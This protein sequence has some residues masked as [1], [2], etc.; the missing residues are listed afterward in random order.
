[1]KKT[2]IVPHF[3]GKASIDERSYDVL[4]NASSSIEDVVATIKGLGIEMRQNFQ[5]VLPA[6]L[7]AEHT[8][9]PLGAVEG[10]KGHEVHYNGNIEYVRG[11]EITSIVL[12]ILQIHGLMS[13]T[14]VIHESPTARCTEEEAEAILALLKQYDMEGV[15]SITHMPNPSVYRARKTLQRVI[16]PSFGVD[17]QSPNEVIASLL[18]SGKTLSPEHQML[19]QAAQLRPKEVIKG[20]AEE[21][22]NI[23]LD[24]ASETAHW[25]RGNK[26][27]KPLVWLANRQRKD[28]V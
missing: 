27:Q 1:M 12:Q 25:L 16:P 8:G 26:G 14:L 10:W 20:I 15:F 28:H 13:D 21:G 4:M 24:I 7:L 6:A 22:I 2:L 9:N 11:T 5:R 19:M 18:A 3:R 23:T 17:V